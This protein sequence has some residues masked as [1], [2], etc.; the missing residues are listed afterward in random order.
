MIA[1]IL[2]AL[3]QTPQMSTETTIELMNVCGEQVIEHALTMPEDATLEEIASDWLEST[4]S[5]TGGRWRDRKRERRTPTDP[6]EVQRGRRAWIDA[7]QARREESKRQRHEYRI[8]RQKTKQAKAENRFFTSL[9]WGCIGLS[10]L[11]V[12]I[13]VGIKV[14]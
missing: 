12:V 2:F 13:L 7:L 14:I 5:T 11:A 4:P 8:E 6:E 3:L 1:F 9:F 10:V